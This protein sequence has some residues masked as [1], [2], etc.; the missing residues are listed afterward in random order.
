MSVQMQVSKDVLPAFLACL[1]IGT[2]H[3]IRMGAV[4]AE[5]GTWTLA[6]PRF[7]SPIQDRSMAPKEVIEVCRVCDELG[8]IQKLL[9]PGEFDNAVAELIERLRAVLAQVD[10]DWGMGFSWLENSDEDVPNRGWA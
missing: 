7:L 1:G 9:G 5:A 2:L 3:A 8:A 6:S 4:P 10:P